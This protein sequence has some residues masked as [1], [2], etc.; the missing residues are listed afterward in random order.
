MAVTHWKIQ[1]ITALLLIP[2]VIIFL[3]YMFEIGKL[4]YVEILNDLSS[5]T[6]LIVIILSTLILYMHS[7]MG[8]EVIIEDYIHDILWQKI[9]INISKILHFILFISTLFLIFLIRG[10]Y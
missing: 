9:L 6:G 1:R 7:S 10:N 8:M 3:G 5:T 4:S 2:V